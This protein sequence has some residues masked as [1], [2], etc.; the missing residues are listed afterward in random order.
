MLEKIIEAAFDEYLRTDTPELLAKCN[1]MTEKILAED[2]PNRLFILDILQ[3][4]GS[5]YE[6]FA[7]E[8]G[9]RAC[10]KSLHALLGYTET[11]CEESTVK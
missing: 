6:T 9:F 2:N 3:D 1:E 5:D 7:F 4:I 10:V 11:V 8:A